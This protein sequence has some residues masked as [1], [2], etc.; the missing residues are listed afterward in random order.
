[1]ALLYG[2]ELARSP[3]SQFRSARALLRASLRDIRDPRVRARVRRTLRRLPRDGY[4]IMALMAVVES[5]T[6][7]T[8]V[9]PLT[10][11]HDLGLAWTFASHSAERRGAPG[12]IP[13]AASDEATRLEGCPGARTAWLGG[14]VA[15]RAGCLP[16]DVHV[17]AA[18]PVRIRLPLGTGRSDCR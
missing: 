17:G 18:T 10:A 2:R 6:V 5:G 3:R 9:V 1:V 8:I 14:F 4:P 11:Q 7:A 13:F 16:L 12:I 15:R